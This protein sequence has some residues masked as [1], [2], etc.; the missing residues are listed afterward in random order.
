[1]PIGRV[2]MMTIQPIRTSESLCGTGFFHFTKGIARN[3]LET[4]RTMSRQK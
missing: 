1:M 4:M 3:H 2:P